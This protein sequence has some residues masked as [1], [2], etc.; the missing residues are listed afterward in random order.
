[1]VNGDS[2]KLQ[3]LSLRYNVDD[4]ICRRLGLSSAYVSLS[5]TNLFTVA[6]KK[7]RGQDVTTQSGNSPTINLSLRPSYSLTLN[8]TL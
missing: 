1:M 8:I 4:A 7:L 2:L 5:G 6:N 3:S